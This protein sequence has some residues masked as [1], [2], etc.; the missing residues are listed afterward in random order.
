MA[1][2]PSRSYVA[3]VLEGKAPDEL[4]S[5]ADPGSEESGSEGGDG[6]GGEATNSSNSNTTSAEEEVAVQ[7]D[8]I[9]G[10]IAGTHSPKDLGKSTSA[11]AQ[12][13]QREKLSEMG[14]IEEA[15]K[16]YLEIANNKMGEW[17][18]K[19]EDYKSKAN[20]FL[21]MPSPERMLHLLG[22]KF[23]NLNMKA[24]ARG[25]SIFNTIFCG[26]SNSLLYGLV[27]LIKALDFNFAF[28]NTWNICGRKRLRNPLEIYTKT[29][30]DIETAT[31]HI[32]DTPGRLFRNLQTACTNFINRNGLPSDLANCIKN[33]AVDDAVKKI[34]FQISLE[35]I[36]DLNKFFNFKVCS[37]S[38]QGFVG[39][40]KVVDRIAASPFIK[41]LGDY[42][43]KNRLAASLGIFYKPDSNLDQSDYLEILLPNLFDDN[44][45]DKVVNN[46]EV[47][48]AALSKP[49][50]PTY[51][52]PNNNNLNNLHGYIH[53]ASKEQIENI[54]QSLI[55]GVGQGLSVGET[56]SG[57]VDDS[58]AST[59]KG[60]LTVDV[61]LLFKNM[62]DDKSEVSNP[63]QEFINIVNM[64]YVVNNNFDPYESIDMLSSSKT[65][66]DLAK[67]VISS[68]PPLPRQRPVMIEDIEYHVAP[69]DDHMIL[70]T[71]LMSE[72]TSTCKCGCG[73]ICGCDGLLFLN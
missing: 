43:D 9:V 54:K 46:L 23:P 61:C 12:T 2:H 4:S 47:I 57:E 55:D 1:V 13:A 29:M 72:T 60:L 56:L 7:Q 52:L 36:K 73:G 49:V 34:K 30:E 10:G 8:N 37:K 53:G 69:K 25:M 3:G 27:D 28:L 21:S 26:D 62:E 42:D 15:S 14:I 44:K 66:S 48:M 18:A 65:L 31:N 67:R 64:V 24:V 41:G 6:G 39:D 11:E 58:V 22:E 45:K 5:D 71:A 51:T 40:N 68:R 19:L 33:K 38:E 17:A 59:I 32:L 16:D 20:D 63:E 70:D 50:E 35:G